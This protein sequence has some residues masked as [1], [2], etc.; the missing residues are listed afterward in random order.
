[1]SDDQVDLYNTVYGKYSHEVETAVRAETYGKDIGQSGWMTS[2]EYARFA[3]MLDLTEQS[4]L[5]DVAAGSGGTTIF[6]GERTG[7]RVTGVDINETGVQNANRLA[8]E[9]GV[10]DRIV[11]QIADAGIRL[12]FQDD[13]FDALLCVDAITHLPDRPSVFKEWHRVLKP[14]GRLVFTDPIIITGLVSADEVL[15]RSSIGY[16]TYAAPGVDERLLEETGF[17]EVLVQ[18]LTKNV[19]AVGGRWHDARETRRE[20]LVQLEGEETFSG[21]QRFL[22]LVRTLADERRLSCSSFL[23]RKPL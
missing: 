20:Q 2:G 19:G 11:F 17:E 8:A 13:T 21:L 15:V 22:S 1:M 23:A 12:P 10:S 18:D 3:D 5:L 7:C 4:H 16:F 9:A 6:I 14:G